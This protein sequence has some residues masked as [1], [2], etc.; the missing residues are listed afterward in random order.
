M[1]PG[2]LR[3]LQKG[4]Q[5]VDS[6]FYVMVFW[7]AVS[8]MLMFKHISNDDPQGASIFW[9]WGG[10]LGWLLLGTITQSC[11]GMISMHPGAAAE[12][13]RANDKAFSRIFLGWLSVMCDDCKWHVA[14]G[15]LF[16]PSYSL[17]SFIGG[18]TENC[19]NQTTQSLWLFPRCRSMVWSE[20]PP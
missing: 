7:L 15:M 2:E 18:F 1:A 14:S 19:L 16:Q 10:T 3:K 12:S 11:N 17:L 6:Q 8:S 20:M 13:P 4:W 5:G 9:R